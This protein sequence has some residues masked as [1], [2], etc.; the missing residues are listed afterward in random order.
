MSR[1]AMSSK[2]GRLFQIANR[3][4]AAAVKDQRSSALHYW[5]LGC[6]LNQAKADCPHGQ[7]QTT[8]RARC[9]GISLRE[10]QNYMRLARTYPHVADMRGLP[11]RR[12]LA[13]LAGPRP[14]EQ[15]AQRVAPLI[16]RA[17]ATEAPRRKQVVRVTVGPGRDCSPKS[18]EDAPTREVGT[19]PAPPMTCY[20]ED[21]SDREQRYGGTPRVIEALQTIAQIDDVTRWFADLSPATRKCVCDLVPRAVAVLQSVGVVSP[22]Y[23]AVTPP[24][25]GDAR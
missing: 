4:Y 18:I 25:I 17:P 6:A 11:L 1:Y 20:V 16:I 19:G 3:E 14:I 7:W 2:L 15:E 12:L 10:V 5:R 21:L 23:Q 13:E 8:V 9:P 22:R 24:P